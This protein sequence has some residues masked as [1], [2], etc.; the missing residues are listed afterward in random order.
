MKCTRVNEDADFDAPEVNIPFLGE[1]YINKAD[2]W[3]VFIKFS[4]HD[5][6]FKLDIGGV[7]SVMSKHNSVALMEVLTS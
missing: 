7:V 1:I 6:C 5:T 3:T 4:G 2:F